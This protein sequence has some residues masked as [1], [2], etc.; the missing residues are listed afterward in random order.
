MDGLEDIY[1]VG[2][3]KHDGSTKVQKVYDNSS[4]GKDLAIQFQTLTKTTPADVVIFETPQTMGVGGSTTSIAAHT[5][6]AFAKGDKTA[7][8][9]V[10]QNME[11]SYGTDDLTPLQ[12][13]L[14]KVGNKGRRLYIVA[15]DA[16]TVKLGEESSRGAEEGAFNETHEF[17]LHVIDDLKRD[18]N[19]PAPTSNVVHSKYYDNPNL[20][21]VPKGFPNSDSYDEIKP[22]STAG[23]DKK[24]IQDSNKSVQTKKKP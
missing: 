15:M 7:I 13:V 6:K 4:V 12:D 10:K 20:K 2:L 8:A 24:S 22:K 16:G 14:V 18:P 21:D 11:K 5:M 23:Q 1:Y 19:K 9:Q 3:F 17:R